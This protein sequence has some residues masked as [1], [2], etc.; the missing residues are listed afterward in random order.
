MVMLKY[1]TYRDNELINEG[2]M[3]T[4][5]SDIEDAFQI[6][7]FRALKSDE[8]TEDGYN[9]LLDDFVPFDHFSVTLENGR[10]TGFMEDWHGIQ[11]TVEI[12]GFYFEDIAVFKFQIQDK[13]YRVVVQVI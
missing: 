8:T 2:E 10:I 1:E 4:T 5:V 9:I 11:D 7:F 12:H 6:A 3:I 13:K